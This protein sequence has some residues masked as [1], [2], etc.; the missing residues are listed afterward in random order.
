MV[1]PLAALPDAT[2]LLLLLGSNSSIEQFIYFV[3]HSDGRKWGPQ[4]SPPPPDI[5]TRQINKLITDKVF[6]IIKARVQAKDE[7]KVYGV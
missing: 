5:G 4:P 3:P 1:V 2:R 7:P 6:K